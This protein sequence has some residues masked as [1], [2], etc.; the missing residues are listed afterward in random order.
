MSC[1]LWTC[2]DTERVPCCLG[3]CEHAG[4]LRRDHEGVAGLRGHRAPEER[5]HHQHR[6]ECCVKIGHWMTLL[7]LSYESGNLL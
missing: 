3:G 4:G 6:C 1:I 5:V 2:P 7:T